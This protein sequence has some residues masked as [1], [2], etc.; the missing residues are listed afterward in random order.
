MFVYYTFIIIK[1][2]WH[3][4]NIVGTYKMNIIYMYDNS[5]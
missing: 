3:K 4:Y 1:S 2:N 5:I